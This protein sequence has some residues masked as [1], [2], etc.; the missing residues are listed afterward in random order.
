[1][2]VLILSQSYFAGS[3]GR[4]SRSCEEREVVVSSSCSK[5]TAWGRVLVGA[6]CGALLAVLSCAPASAQTI[7]VAVAKDAEPLEELAGSELQRYLARLFPVSASVVWEPSE[8]ADYAFLVGVASRNAAVTAGGQAFPQLTDQGFV[9]RTMTFKEKPALAVVGGSPVA[10]MWAVYELVERYG[11]RYLL[12]GDVFP[13]SQQQFFLPQMD[14]VFEPTFRIRMWKAMGDFAFGME[15]WGMADY[16]PFLDQLAKLKFNRIRVSNGPTQPF[17]EIYVKGIKRETATLW[18]AE[19]FPITEDMPGRALF[20]NEK[21]FWNPDLPMPGASCDAMIEAGVRHCRE[22][23]AYAHGRGLGSNFVGSITDFPKEF[24]PAVPGAQTVN[25]LGQLTVAPGPTA[26]PDNPELKE[27]AGTVLKSIVDTYPDADSYGFPVGT[28]WPSWVELYEWSWQELNA[29]YKIDEIASL[30]AVLKAASERTEFTGG[31]E[32]AV[33]HV[34]GDLTGLCFMDLLRTD[35]GILPKTV[36]PD[37]KFMYYEISEELFPIL[38]R[39]LGKGSELSIVLDYTPTRVLRRQNVLATV[40]EPEIPTILALTLQDDGV[41][42][43]PQLTTGN[44]HKLVTAMR[45]HGMSGFCTRQWMIS[46]LDPCVA[47][48]AKA[49]WDKTATP[50]AAYRD[51]ILAVCGK[52][53]IEPM[54]EAFRQIEAVTEALERDDLGIGFPVPNMILRHWS[55]GPI[56]PRYVENREGYRRALAAVR[57][58]SESTE[59]GGRAY[60]R[61]WVGRLEFGIGFFDTI[62]AIKRAATAEQAAKDAK[63]QGN[64]AA[65]RAKA[66]EALRLADQAVK[67]AFESIDSLAK[68]SRNRADNGAVATMAEYIFRALQRKTEEMKKEF[69]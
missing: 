34:K 65:Y 52:E 64:D 69:A 60:V 8:Q 21:E 29:R 46:D 56:E 32:R 36:K 4:I 28:E 40:P 38:K 5:Q 7:E 2:R 13:Q 25:Q 58:A 6:F 14:A 3:Q 54:L 24:A 62:E 48:L 42:V 20:G 45:E 11:V 35:P 19:H 37:A 50:D 26:K 15:G 59:E 44:L 17:L 27:I 66:A 18:Y 49:A 41:G 43:P 33:N 51:Q 39:V 12:S 68:V 63:Q 61:Y 30:D 67:A 23:I 57:K 55:P 53:A 22:L 47:Y 16:R 1:M 31:A 9:L 10:T